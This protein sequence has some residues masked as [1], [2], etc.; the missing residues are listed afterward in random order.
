MASSQTD[1]AQPDTRPL[2]E[3]VDISG[4]RLA[5]VNISRQYPGVLANDQV[6]LA[7]AAGQIH[8]L[9]GENG[10]GKST[11]MK[12]AYGLVAPD[13]GEIYWEGKRQQIESPAMARQLG[14]GM[15]FQHFSLFESLTVT[16]NIALMLP[17]ERGDRQLAERIAQLGERYGL[18]V[19]P[20]AHIADLSVGE[21]QR[22]EIIR[23]LLLEP[24]LLILD[25]PTSVLTPQAAEALFDTLRRLRDEGV[26][27]LY[28]SHKL[29]EVRRLCDEAT[30]LRGGRVTGNCHPA[31]ESVASLSQMMLGETPPRIRNATEQ[32]AQDVDPVL[33]VQ[34]LFRPGDGT[35]S[36]TIRVPLL[37]VRPGEVIGIAGISGNGQ[38]ELLNLLS[39]EEILAA[40]ERAGAQVQ[41]GGVDAI[42]M[43]VMQR[44]ALGLAFVPEERLGRGA[45]PPMNLFWNMLLTHQG[46][47]LVRFGLA[48]PRRLRALARRVIDEF[49]VKTPSERTAAESLSG[50]NLQK[51]IVGREMIRAPRLLLVSQ[52]TWGVDVGAAA[53]IRQALIDLAAAGSAVV[54]VSEDLEELFE[55][56]N[57][58]Y[59]ISDGVLSERL[60]LA[61]TS[62]EQIGSLMGGEVAA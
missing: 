56:S 42:G 47:G 30:V 1:P 27:V 60:D 53:N 29:D 40:D 54:V 52:P 38:N 6:S 15:V 62:I 46:K 31:N 45:V 41:I 32:G 4:A 10:A 7:V 25:E 48:A 28:I 3:P 2:S 18:P 23:C 21:R 13:S 51:L 57:A 37:Q 39:G 61:A 24:K 50:G 11:L 49:A 58:L 43:N 22:V 59:V 34:N 9:I 8:G 5:L 17:G 35:L 44:R 14:I 19:D 33:H 36:R 55:V 12:I 16:E 26:S 20:E